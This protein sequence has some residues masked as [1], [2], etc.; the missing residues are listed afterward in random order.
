MFKNYVHRGEIFAQAVQ[1]LALD[2]GLE[3]DVHGGVQ[4]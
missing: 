1:G 4:I 2:L 3:L